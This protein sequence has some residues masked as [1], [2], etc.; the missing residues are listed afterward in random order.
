MTAPRVRVSGVIRVPGD[1]SISHRALM[2][3]ALGSGASRVTGILRSADVQSTAGILRALGVA[4]PALSEDFVI[5]GVGRRG[6]TASRTQLDCGNSGTSA[7]LLA[8]IAAAQPFSSTFVGD[9]SLSRRPMR[10][11][12]APLEQMGATVT[13]PDHGGLPMTIMGGGLRSIDFHNETSSAQVKSAVLLAACVAGVPVSVIEPLHSRD[14]TER[15]LFARGMHVHLEHVNEGHRVHLAPID[16]L[17]ACDAAV[18]GDPSSAAFF[19]GLAAMAGGG[20]LVLPGVCVNPT[21][22]GAFAVLARM[23]AAIELHDHAEQ[24]G[25]PIAT[26]TAKPGRL[27]AT[28]VGGAEIPSLIDE[29]PLIAC[30]AA[31]AEGETV[32]TGAAELRVKESDRISTVV[33]NLRS[34]GV[35]AHELPDGLRVIGSDRQLMG[36]TVTRGDHRIA[37]AFGILA[38][39]PGNK[40]EIDDRDCVGVSYPS[41]WSDLA[42][43]VST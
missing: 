19:A 21:R 37:M 6:L 7:R 26:L 31:R 5:P 29:L 41:F 14:H 38:A 42:S 18:P 2:L 33:S 40:I 10:R 30:V 24:G 27:V 39:I 28:K 20:E 1:K 12:A 35:E 4:I 16:R 15:M 22:V 9:E 36:P 3:G 17:H 34:I 8:G 32:I 13:L 11:V 23:G 43:A 25:E